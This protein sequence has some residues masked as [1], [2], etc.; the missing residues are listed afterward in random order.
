MT[1]NIRY[2]AKI[3]SHQEKRKA[4]QLIFLDVIVSLLDI[5]F[6]I[7]LLFLVNFFS[8]S[9]QKSPPGIFLFGMGSHS[10]ILLFGIFFLLFVAKNFLGF[11]VMKLQV[12]YVYGVA[13]RLSTQNIV[14]YLEGNYF[15]YANTDSSVFIHKTSEQPIQ[16]AH[17]VLSGIQQI[18][19]QS[20]LIFFSIAALLVYNPVLFLMLLLVLVP[21]VLT[22]TFFMKKKMADTRNKAKLL[23]ERTI[24]YLKEALSAFVESNVYQKKNFF[25][26]RYSGAQANFNNLLSEQL[27]IRNI[28]SRLIEVFMVFGLGILIL[29][30]SLH[31][32][33]GSTKLMIIGAF[34]AAAYKVIP[35][36]VKIMAS[37]SQIKS[38]SYTVGELLR[39]Q[40][41][42]GRKIAAMKDPDQITTIELSNVS[43]NYGDKKILDNFS[44]F[45]Q[46][47]EMI[48]LSGL[49]GK[50]K[51]TLIN[52]LLGFLPPDEGCILV[53]GRVSNKQ[54]RQNLWKNISYVK[55]QPMLIHDTVLK[56][57]TLDDEECDH[58]RLEEV[59]HVTGLRIL[60]KDDK[61]G[62]NKV[63]S[64]NG[65]NL[66]G[67]QRQRIAIARALYKNAQ[68]IILD[69]P[70]SELDKNSEELFVCYFRQLAISGKIVLLIT[71]KIESL[72]FC[73]KIISLDEKKH[74]FACD[75]NTRVSRGGI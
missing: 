43:F 4:I 25:S 48:G 7:W 74:S 67:G 39:F 14:R 73:H 12:K 44:C 11:L 22:V 71:H 1:N 16:F 49:S 58:K 68:V 17:Y 18:I 5:V 33:S 60:L 55:Q 24:Q 8:N 53:N 70:F 37:N 20:L 66:S 35:G 45:M 51:T 21:A 75:F 63:I 69:E 6:L 38:Y 36:I 26:K 30:E 19:S 40:K 9:T 57:I 31:V 27:V 65:K 10:P 46:R 72:S 50:G 61:E 41:R 34:V 59:L 42:A 3:L 23:S 2:I 13:S 47:G 15:D 64:E 56:N 54:E 29:V 28:P 62:C 52:L 32:N